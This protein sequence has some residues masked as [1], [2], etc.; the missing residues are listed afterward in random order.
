MSFGRG[1]KLDDAYDAWV[2]RSP[3]EDEYEDK[4]EDEE[5]K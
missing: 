1:K 4:E 2:T 5:E 3:D